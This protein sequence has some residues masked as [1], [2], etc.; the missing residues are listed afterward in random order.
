MR[1]VEF[2]EIG[3]ENFGPYIDPMILTFKNNSLVLI[4]GPNGI[5][6]TMAIEA[7]P[8][9]LF[10]ITSKGVKG[11]DVVNNTVGKNCKTWSKFKVNSIPHI[12]TRYHKYSK[13]GGNTVILNVN[14]V[15]TKRGQKEV[16]PEIE[17]II[18]PRKSFMNTLMFGQ[19]IKDFFT[20]LIDSD[21]KDIFRKILNLGSYL[22]FYQNA[23]DKIDEIEVKI[24]EI[25]TQDGINKGLLKDTKEQ[26]IILKEQQKD[27]GN[28]IK[29]TIKNLSQSLE[30]NQR[31]FKHWEQNLE[32]VKKQDIDIEKTNSELSKYDS[33]LSNMKEKVN[34]SITVLESKKTTKIAEIQKQA[35]DAQNKIQEKYRKIKQEIT[36]KLTKTNLELREY[37]DEVTKTKHSFDL[38][39]S[40]LIMEQSNLE[41]R[42]DEIQVKVLDAKV[43][44]CPLCEQDV[45]DKTVDLLVSKVQKSNDQIK[46]ILLN[47]EKLKEKRNELNKMV[48]KESEIKGTEIT[49]FNQQII[50]EENNENIQIK[51]IDNKLSVAIEKI[52]ILA[53][54][55][56]QKINSE[57]KDDQ[58]R[59]TQAIGDLNK[60][61]EDQIKLLDKVKEIEITITNFKSQILSN[62]KEIE[63]HKEKQYDETQLK[64]YI[65]KEIEII[66]DSEKLY[67]ESEEIS[68]YQEILNFWKMGFSSSG[69]PSMLIDEAIPF[70]NKKISEYLEKLTNGRY[71][72]SFDT[73][74][75]IKSG[76]FR[77]KISVNVIDTYTRANS[78]IQLSGGQ[79]RIIDIATILTLGDLQSSVQDVMFNILLFDEIFDS[80]DEE[81]IGFVSKVLMNLKLNKSIYL[82]SHR[83]VDQLEPDEI[84]ELRG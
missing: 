37:V 23:K 12:V 32:Q 34:S 17:R 26:I 42:I 69:I 84:L 25:K 76:E 71:I 35:S 5:G 57:L 1:E 60:K 70:M 68:A 82:I 73:M 16:L 21:K 79:T 4:T 30:E 7:L 50:K 18:C 81:N 20:D 62:E 8:F 78:R 61:K 52:N 36:E 27:F 45:T 67:K 28:Q 33:E 11:D 56:L 54:Q 41:T 59:V 43:S 74:A 38:Q 10:G 39:N 64:S 55:E 65:R 15:D 14:G 72:V 80:L 13:F 29:E 63:F 3:M 24:N 58:E 9:T 77:D 49:N 6:K 31:L 22:I 40:K 83:H 66:N 46:M 47:L 75:A 19:K 48:E 53:S 2:Q 44:E 51:D